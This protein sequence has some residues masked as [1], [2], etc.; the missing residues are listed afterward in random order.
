MAEVKIE[1]VPTKVRTYF[2][3]GVSAMESKNLD[4]AMDMFMRAAELEPRLLEARKYLH[5]LSIQEAQGK[6]AGLGSM[7]AGT[8][9]ITKHLK[10]KKAD[11]QVAVVEGEKLLRKD[12]LNVKFLFAYTDA[13]IAAEI[14]EAA[15]QALELAREEHK[16]NSVFMYKLGETYTEAGD[17][18]KAVAIWED[19]YRANPTDQVALKRY[20]DA[21]ANATITGS[22]AGAG[23]EGGYREILKD[24]EE[25]ERLEQE[26]RGKK[27]ADD[28]EQLIA[29]LEEKIKHDPSN[30]NHYLRIAELCADSEDY[31][32][33]IDWLSQANE[34]TGGTD[35]QIERAISKNTVAIYDHNIAIL[36][37]NGDQDQAEEFRQQRED[38]LLEDLANCVA[39]YPN[40]LTYKFSYGQ[41]LYQRGDIDGAIPN[42]QKAQNNPAKRTE[43]LY[44]LGLCFKQKGQLDLAAE[45][46]Q[47]AASEMPILDDLKKDVIYE[48]G[49]IYE[50]MDN[51]ELAYGQFKQ[52]YMVDSAYKDISTKMDP[53]YSKTKAS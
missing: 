35:P 47:K 42:F 40:D 15:V 28:F 49:I 30:L 13:C 17:N 32:T 38:F 31:E 9:S 14:P 8:G 34:L 39:K 27:S 25:A 23:S 7:L 3:K 1:E 20:K 46:L 19:I 12:P 5:M 45:Q 4:Y 33:A 51:W 52:I 53:N 50:E 29:G 16:D 37:E 24:S 36:L 43:T 41:K 26:S 18:Q 22:Y 6:K 44:Y 48:I 2:D 10:G 21:S 11:P